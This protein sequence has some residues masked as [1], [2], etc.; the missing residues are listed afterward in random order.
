[1]YRF[2]FETDLSSNFW[3]SFYFICTDLIIAGTFATVDLVKGNTSDDEWRATPKFL[4]LFPISGSSLLC[5]IGPNSFTSICMTGLLLFLCG[6][7]GLYYECLIVIL[8]NE[9]NWTR[10]FRKSTALW[11]ILG[12]RVFWIRFSTWT[13]YSYFF[14]FSDMIAA[15]L[16]ASRSW[17]LRKLTEPPTLW[18]W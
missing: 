8:S 2:V 9:S 3:S 13:R 6:C 17:K 5:L 16:C 15:F 4:E 12:S 7:G 1:M 10:S 14:S 18:L 11:L